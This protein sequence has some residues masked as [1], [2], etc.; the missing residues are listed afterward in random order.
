MP[1]IN[2]RRL[3]IEAGSFS[4]DSGAYNDDLPYWTRDFGEPFLIL[5][6]SLAALGVLVLY[7]ASSIT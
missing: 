7:I 1:S 6:V 2:T 4:Y 3:V 5:P